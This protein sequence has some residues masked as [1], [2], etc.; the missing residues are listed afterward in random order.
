MMT[1]LEASSLGNA[2]LRDMGY[3]FVDVWMKTRV[4][5]IVGMEG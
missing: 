4:V 3:C 5:P 2:D 1:V